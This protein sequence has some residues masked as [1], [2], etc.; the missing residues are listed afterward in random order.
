MRR[1]P[2][3]SVTM[4]V[5]EQ[6]DGT[7]A[8]VPEW[9]EGRSSSSLTRYG[10]RSRARLVGGGDSRTTSPRAAPRVA[11]SS[12]S[13]AIRCTA[14]CSVVGGEGNLEQGRDRRFGFDGFLGCLSAD[15]SEGYDRL[16]KPRLLEAHIA[17]RS[18]RWNASSSNCWATRRG[19]FMR[20]ARSIR[21]GPQAI[22]LM[23]FINCRVPQCAAGASVLRRKRPFRPS[24]RDQQGRGSY[25][26]YRSTTRSCIC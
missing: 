2:F 9:I 12:N 7:M 22:A 26:N 17:R 15:V 24:S 18:C 20:L 5:I 3:R 10:A 16:E 19:S 1:H 6:P 4:L 14:I 23:Y 13:L 8:L 21:I 25:G 11:G